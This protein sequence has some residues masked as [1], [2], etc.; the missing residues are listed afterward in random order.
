MIFRQRRATGLAFS[1]SSCASSSAKLVLSPISCSSRSRYNA[2]SSPKHYVLIMLEL[3]PR[4]GR[5]ED[6]T[7]NNSTNSKNR[8][9]RK[10]Q[11]DRTG[12]SSSGR[13][14]WVTEIG[15]ASK[16]KTNIDKMP[17]TP[18]HC[19]LFSQKNKAQ[20][21]C[22]GLSFPQNVSCAPQRCP[23]QRMPPYS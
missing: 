3:S 13:L 21:P 2:A 15:R 11:E 23:S 20:A 19:S 16:A 5:V 9:Q 6:N 18:A 1:K 22:D 12:A 10:T 4:R 7:Y 14:P 8:E 17:P